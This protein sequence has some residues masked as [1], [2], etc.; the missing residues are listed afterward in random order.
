MKKPKILWV[1]EATFLNT[2]YANYGRE[3][4]QRLYASDKYEIAE[5][6]CYAGQ[7]HVNQYDRCKWRFYFGL[8]ADQIEDQDY[9]KKPTNQFGEWRFN[10]VV[11]D[12][13]P[14]YVLSITDPWMNSYQQLSPYRSFYKWI[15]MPTVDSEPL[16]DE[17]IATYEDA[18]VLL[19]Y[20]EFGKDVLE[21]STNNVLKVRAVT[22]P[23]INFSVFK[24]TPIEQARQ[25]LHINPNALIVGTVMR[26]QKRK[27]FPDLIESFDMLVDA[28]PQIAS[29]LYLYLHTSY[30][31]LG[32]DLPRMIRTSKYPHRIILTYVCRECKSIFAHAYTDSQCYCP[33]C[34][35]NTLVLTNTRVGVT[36]EQL[37][38]IYSVMDCYV[39]YAIC[40]GFGMPAIEAAA[41]D[42]PVVACDYSA[43]SSVVERLGG[44][45]IKIDRFFREAETH[46][47]RSY[48][49]NSD[50][51][52]KLSTLLN[53]PSNL[54][55]I[56]YP[57]RTN[58][59]REYNWDDVAM[60]WI[61][62][63]NETSTCET[64]T[65]WDVAPRIIN[66]QPQLINGNCSNAE[67]VDQCIR[68]ILQSLTTNKT[69]MYMALRK[70]R[71]LNEGG[72]S[73]GLKNNM[74][75]PESYLGTMPSLG[76]YSR[77]QCVQECMELVEYFN[78]WENRRLSGYVPPISVQHAKPDDKE[79]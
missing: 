6:G 34:G 18:D 13:K 76:A 51:V 63:L 48:P 27:L 66:A 61:K 11:L 31:D 67:F 29:Q 21:K 64:T 57:M 4:L 33:R 40:E 37:A 44:I 28:N 15:V 70:L 56:R 9:N 49:S 41:C 72:I 19:A 2:G 5:Y 10:D 26:N 39:Q 68:Y 71:Q 7:Q 55:S 46:A 43:M 54:R 12:F 3:L 8:P 38:Q 23:A 47:Y 45:P 20:S 53:M 24:P 58:C 1:G 22:S 62:I 36:E 42:V 16:Q 59:M 65:G 75:A 78:K 69:I 79:L 30:P 74:F 35:Q 60:M 32:W 77:E 14:D 25:F 17:W 73:H 52:E 50:F